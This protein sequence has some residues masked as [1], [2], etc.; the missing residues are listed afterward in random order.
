MTATPSF[1]LVLAAQLSLQTGASFSGLLKLFTRAP[2]SAL[3]TIATRVPR[4]LN[5][6]PVEFAAFRSVVAIR[7]DNVLSDRIADRVDLPEQPGRQL[8]TT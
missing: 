4:Y 6:K 8:S 1:D 2:S 7:S 5:V 3:F